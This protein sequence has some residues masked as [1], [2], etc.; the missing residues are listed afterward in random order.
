MN[1][2][3]FA[4]GSMVHGYSFN[5][6]TRCANEL[7]RVVDSTA[8]RMKGCSLTWTPSRALGAIGGTLRIASIYQGN[9]GT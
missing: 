8:V 2:L 5:S 3:P 6:L 1:L 7:D 4:L 9:D